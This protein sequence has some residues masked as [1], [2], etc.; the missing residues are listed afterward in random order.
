MI[1]I[2]LLGRASLFLIPQVMDED[3]CSQQ[4]TDSFLVLEQLSTNLADRLTVDHKKCVKKGTRHKLCHSS[5]QTIV[6]LFGWPGNIV[7]S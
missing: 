1:R 7:A 6:S 4:A 3:S 2:T 5:R